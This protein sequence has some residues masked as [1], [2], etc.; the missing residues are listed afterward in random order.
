MN[1]STS[2]LIPSW[3]CE[4]PLL[5]GVCGLP[6]GEMAALPQFA[7][8]VTPVIPVGCPNGHRFLLRVASTGDVVTERLADVGALAIESEVA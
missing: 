1:D 2:Q 4:E 6:L 7:Q 5:F 3:R 8:E